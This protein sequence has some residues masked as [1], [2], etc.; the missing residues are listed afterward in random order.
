M[1]RASRDE[2]RELDDPDARLRDLRRRVVPRDHLV[3]D[4]LRERQAHELPRNDLRADAPHERL[5]P[6]P[7]LVRR[8]RAD[9]GV[10]DDEPR[11]PLR[12]LD[13]E[14]E[15]DRAAPVLHDE[16]DALQVELAHETRHR[17]DVAVVGVPLRLRRLV[18]APEPEVVRRDAPRDPLER[19]DH[20]PVE[21][22]PRRL[23][24][25]EQHRVTVSLVDVVHAQPVLVEIARLEPEAGQA[26]EPRIRRAID[27]HSTTCSGSG[28]SSTIRSGRSIGSSDLTYD[29]TALS[30][31]TSLPAASERNHR[32]SSTWW[33]ISAAGRA[34]HMFSGT[35]AIVGSNTSSR[36]RDAA[37]DSD[38][39][40]FSLRSFASRK[41]AMSLSIR[42]AW[43]SCASRP[44]S[45]SSRCLWWPGSTTCGSRFSRY[46]SGVAFSWISSTS[47]PSAF[48]RWS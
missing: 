44:V 26:V 39:D 10:H 48:N 24:V 38:S 47:K 31:P 28:R 21:K 7:L 45:R 16:R 1:L 3:R 20:R 27:A 9:P 4:G 5:E 12:L 8:T 40:R 29:S 33:K 18:G 46:P 43:F 25:Q 14:P 15:A 37:T 34:A 35:A 42:R 2:L 17:L 36:Q 23:A 11:D 19:R 6:Q 13:R 32:C 22:R 30:M 41:R